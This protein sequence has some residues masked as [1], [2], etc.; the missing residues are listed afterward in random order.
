[1]RVYRFEFL[2]QR[3]VYWREVGAD[4]S[5]RVT[6]AVKAPDKEAGRIAAEGAARR[7]ADAYIRNEV[8]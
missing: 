7:Y 5:R 1:M 2:I 4:C 6:F 8:D 3:P